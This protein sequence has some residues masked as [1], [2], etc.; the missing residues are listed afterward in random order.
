MYSNAV[1]MCLNNLVT[2]TYKTAGQLA[3]K[4]L[5]LDKILLNT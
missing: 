3:L 1:V 5:I 2:H 4:I